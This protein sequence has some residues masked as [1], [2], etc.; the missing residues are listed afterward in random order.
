MFYFFSTTT[1]IIGR[2]VASDPAENPDSYMRTS[3]K[4]TR[5]RLRN[6]KAICVK[7]CGLKIKRRILDVWTSCKCRFMW[8]CKVE[9]ETC[10]KKT[11]QLTCTT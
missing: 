4:S 11:V 9:C 3:S 2:T 5:E 6:F 10:R 7:E 1:G 8:C